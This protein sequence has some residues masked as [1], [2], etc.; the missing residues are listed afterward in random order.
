MLGSKKQERALQ[1]SSKIAIEVNNLSKCYQIYE[2][3]QDRL[4]QFILPHVYRTMGITPKT[5]FKEFWALSEASF[6]I[7]KGETIGVIGRNGSGKSTLLQLICGVLNPSNGSLKINGRVAAL[8]ELGS[9]FN[10]EFTG[11]ENV[12]LNANVLGLSIREVDERYEKIIS[13]ADI[14][15]FINHP[16]KTYSSGMVVRL[17]FAVASSVDPEILIVDEALAVGD[18]EFQAKCY[19]RFQELR[20]NG[21]TVILV[22]HDIGAVIQL[23]NRAIV[24]QKGKIVASGLP[25]EM[26]D[27]YRR[28]C[29]EESSQRQI[30]NTDTESN[31]RNNTNNNDEGKWLPQSA[32]T[33]EYGDGRAKIEYFSIHDTKGVSTTIINADEPII[34]KMKIKFFESCTSPIAAFGIRDLTGLELSGT[35]TWYEGKDI[36]PV[37]NGDT[38]IIDFH[39]KT[40][41]QS[42]IYNLTMACTELS[43][44]GLTVLHRLFDVAVLEIHA[45]RRFV[46]R[47][48]LK[49]VVYVYRE[50]FLNE[51][52]TG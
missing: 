23:C 47:F 6:K 16:V 44:E 52:I 24:L 45:S 13:F 7:Q 18:A 19:R 50:D 43:G 36:G 30:K 21:V 15:D 33:Q 31:Y 42:G 28:L 46:G 39:F 9:G 4:K 22:T 27:E 8:L 25:K 48:D 26:G 37:K 5:Y 51:N 1:M 20:N 2:K 14:G 12:Y 17:A 29:A 49:P 35:N 34:L 3:P 41:L 38:V 10:P 11:K 32:Q 40:N